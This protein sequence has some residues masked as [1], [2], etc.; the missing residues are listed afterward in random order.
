MIHATKICNPCGREFVPAEYLTEAQAADTVSC[1]RGC[2]SARSNGFANGPGKA[3]D[4]RGGEVVGGTGFDYKC[5][6][7][8]CKIL[9][10]TDRSALIAATAARLGM[11]VV[12]PGTPR[13]KM[14]PADLA[15]LAAKIRKYRLEYLDRATESGLSPPT[16]DIG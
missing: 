6:C 13:K 2:S 11:G 16:E 15:K 1:S 8:D 5:R 14:E 9:A 3:N 10:D 7:E 12:P 4:N